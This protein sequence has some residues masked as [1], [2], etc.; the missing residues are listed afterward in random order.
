MKEIPGYRIICVLRFFIILSFVFYTKEATCQQPEFKLYLVGDAG[1]NE[2]AGETLDSLK[3]KL[4][5]NSNSAL[6]FLG[7]NSYRNAF[8]GLVHYG[9]KG[10]DGGR[11]TQHK[12]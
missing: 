2:I 10:F 6:V 8:F 9:F 11:I 12:L 4:M 7:D 3:S 5:A 1:D